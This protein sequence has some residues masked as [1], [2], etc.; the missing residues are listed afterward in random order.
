MIKKLCIFVCYNQYESKR[1]FTEK[2]VEALER[3]GIEVATLKWPHGAVPVELLEEAKA[4]NPDLTCSFNQPSPNEKGQYFWDILQI[5]HWTILVDPVFYD[6]DMIRSPYS[7]LSCV[8]RSDCQMLQTYFNFHHVF[9]C[10]HAIERDIE[11]KKDEKRDLDVVF[12]GSCYDPDGIRKYWQGQLSQEISKVLDDAIEITLS[13]EHTTFVQ[14]TL[15]A[16]TTHGISPGSVNLPL[17]AFFVDQ[18]TRG[19]DRLQLIR[20]IKNVPVY[21]FGDKCWRTF[22]VASW[23]DYLGSQK[24]IKVVS[25]IDF[26]ETYKILKRTK[27]S[28][29]SM[30][31]FKNGTHERIFLG[32]A[33]GAVPL[34]TRNKFIQE[35][36]IEDEELLFYDFMHLN[37]INEKVVSNISHNNRLEQIAQKGREKVLK[38]FT[39]D[40]CVEAMLE[41]VPPMLQE[42]ISAKS[43]KI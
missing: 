29:N 33:C 10:P 38:N 4:F 1:H 22:P 32:L 20:S 14:A 39:W 13:S 8:D 18:Y 42:I 3:R 9:F 7:I 5:P 36:F 28:L 25:S 15:L 41:K 43:V 23:E 11:L 2:F 37:E 16:L 30:P 26:T 34:T 35:V 40:N 27:I 31:F 12:I 21:V 24:N 6:L 19:M 17:Y